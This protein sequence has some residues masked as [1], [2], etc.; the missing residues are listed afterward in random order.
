MI[1]ELRHCP[2][3]IRTTALNNVALREHDADPNLLPPHHT[4]GHVASVRRQDQGE[5]VGDSS[6]ACYVEHCAGTRQIASHAIDGAVADQNCSG[7]QYAMARGRAP[8]GCVN[9][10][11]FGCWHERFLHE[12]GALDSQSPIHA[13]ETAAMIDVARMGSR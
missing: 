7:P 8:L 11:L 12:A 13:E 1:S 10:A 5:V 9:F 4:A 2:I 3:Q 6:R